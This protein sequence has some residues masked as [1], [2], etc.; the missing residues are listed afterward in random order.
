[1]IVGSRFYGDDNT[2]VMNIQHDEYSSI[3]GELVS[4]ATERYR[5]TEALLNVHTE[6][7]KKLPGPVTGRFDH[8]VVQETHDLIAAFFR[9]KEYPHGSLFK[10]EVDKAACIRRWHQFASQEIGVLQLGGVY[11]TVMSSGEPEQGA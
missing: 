10:E 2:V 9:F 3:I 11:E 8:R 7:G 4:R 6:L 5:Y 1:M